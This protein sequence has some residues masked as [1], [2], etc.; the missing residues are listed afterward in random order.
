MVRSALVAALVLLASPAFAGWPDVWV[1]GLA[2]PQLKWEQEDP[3]VMEAN[4]RNSGFALHRARIQAGMTLKGSH[5]LW[6]ARVEADMVPGF[7]LLDAWLSGTTELA[8]RGWFKAT[9]G[10][11]FA[12]F[13]RQTVV[14]A[15]M[16][17]MVDFA[18]L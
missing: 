5:V 16:L 17:Q 4:P 11:H 12:P 3:S 7:Q 6:E 10:Q 14:P 8:G 9:A 18:Q 2:Q 1:G 13:S 15:H